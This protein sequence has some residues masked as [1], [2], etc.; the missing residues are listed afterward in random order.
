MEQHKYMIKSMTM[1]GIISKSQFNQPRNYHLITWT[2]PLSMGTGIQLQYSK[3]VLLNCF[4]VQFT[5]TAAN[6][7]IPYIAYKS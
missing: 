2:H 7:V 3:N 1:I 6:F 4:K 5:R